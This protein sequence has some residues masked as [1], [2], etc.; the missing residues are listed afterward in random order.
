MSE[1]V[2]SFLA[3]HGVKGMKWGQRKND[4]SQSGDRSSVKERLQVR[5]DNKVATLKGL[6]AKTD[7]SIKELN[8]E[9]KSL[10]PGSRSAYKRSQLYASLK[11]NTKYR[12]ALL[13][14]AEAVKKGGLT[15]T[16]KRLLIGAIGVGALYAASRMTVSTDSGEFNSM[17]LRGQALLKGKKF[18]FNKK[19][20]FARKDLSPDEVLSKVVA[21]VNPNYRNPGGA[22]NCRRSS[23]TYELR[24]RGYDVV[25]TPSRMGTGQSETGLINALTPGKRNITR[26][27]SL[28][29]MVVN[30][31]N[32]RGQVPNDRRTNPAQTVSIKDAS[33]H[34][35]LL[36]AFKDQPNGARGEIVF[37]FQAFGHSM[38]YEI[39]NGT[40]VIFD[41]QKSQ[42][43]EVS[44]DGL[45]KIMQ[46][47]GDVK[48]AEM[49]RLDNIELDTKFLSRWATN[50]PRV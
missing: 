22:I 47:W 37:N 43:H 15:S 33:D 35:N 31:R 45:T 21:G 27:A 48:N 13:K 25:A 29:E 39:F 38:S 44:A 4:D 3:H 32:V 20:S 30:A 6:A 8:A 34:R 10:P 12:D 41:T 14:D 23:F 28:S 40:P 19:P 42:K 1:E 26:T 11:E 7:V 50:T 46:K 5:K 49:T 16:Q 24:R 18:D 36:T 2:E 17:K 9:I